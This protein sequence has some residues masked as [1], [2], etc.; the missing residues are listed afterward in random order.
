VAQSID[1]KLRLIGIAQADLVEKITEHSVGLV[2]ATT[3]LRAVADLLTGS[4]KS[5][6]ETLA[7]NVVEASSSLADIERNLAATGTSLAA[8][9]RSMEVAA[10]E[11]TRAATL[12]TKASGA[13]SAY[14]AASRRGFFSR[15]LGRS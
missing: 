15:L 6:I 4:V 14:G 9:T 7:R 3:D 2:S 13:R 5:D 10:A 1:E 12:V 11:L 8:T